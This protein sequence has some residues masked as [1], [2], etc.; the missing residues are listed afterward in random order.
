M[1]KEDEQ[2]CHW[3]QVCQEVSQ[4]GEKEESELR[5]CS[6]YRGSHEPF[7]RDYVAHEFRCTTICDYHL[8][9]AHISGTD[10]YPESVERAFTMVSVVKEASGD[11]GRTA[12]SLAQANKASSGRYRGGRYRGGPR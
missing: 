7:L 2:G 12:T 1:Q 11:T 5:Q 3:Y 4:I 9:Q 6:S 8:A 10:N